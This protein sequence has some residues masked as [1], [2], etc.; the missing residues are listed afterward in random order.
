MQRLFRRLA[1]LFLALLSCLSIT[2][3][4]QQPG[5]QLVPATPPA[6]IEKAAPALWKVS[7]GDTTIYL[8]GTIHALPP[9]IDWL[10][11]PVAHAFDGSQELVTEIVETEPAHMQALVVERAMLGG[12][13]T[14][15]GLLPA[16]DR[17]K[18]EAALA[19]LGLPA[20]SFDAFDPWFAAIGLATLP[21]TRE[22][23]ASEHGVEKALGARA[24]ARGLPH[25]ALET[26]EYQL[27]LF[28]SLPMDVQQRYLAEVVEQLP[29]VKDQLAA[30]VEAWKHGDAERLAEL[31]N[32]EEDEPA[33]IEAL[34]T[35]RNRA[36]AAWIRERLDKPGTV[37]LA[38]GA[39]H[40]A[41]AGSVQDQLSGLG[42][43]ASRVQ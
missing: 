27:S 11:G 4:A 6:P 42:I 35:R 33:L 34:L 3:S 18:Y 10:G 40:L 15:R 43:A 2:A 8:F 39:G 14:L 22:G 21:L 41:G 13:Q 29:T 32:A 1:C 36:W 20:G 30:M 23:Y 7:D 19:S 26:A 31:M 9:G 28:D 16:A 24:R 17:A 37:F 38:V 12:G 5:P 25:G